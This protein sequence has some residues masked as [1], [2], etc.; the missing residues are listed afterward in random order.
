MSK[1]EVVSN[2]QYTDEFKVEAVRLLS[3]PP[4]S[5]LF[6]WGSIANML[7][8]KQVLDKRRLLL[9]P[10]QMA[11]DGGDHLGSV[12]WPALAQGVGLDVLVEQFIGV[13]LWAVAGQD[14]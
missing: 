14:D 4:N 10:M 8:L 2:R 3:R 11:T 5:A 1:K 6:L 13:K 7:F 9:A 12:G